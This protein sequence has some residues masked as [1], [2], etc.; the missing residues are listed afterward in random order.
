MKLISLLLC[1]TAFSLSAESVQ[2]FSP[3]ESVEILIKTGETV[4]L[5][6][7]YHD[8]MVIEQ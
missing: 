1:I 6:V 2:L 5:A 7:A 4:D 3:D 8:V